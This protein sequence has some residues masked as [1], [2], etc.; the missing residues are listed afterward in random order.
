MNVLIF[1]RFANG[2]EAS[3][4][5]SDFPLVS[6]AN[7]AS[8]AEQ[9]PPKILRFMLQSAARELLPY[10]RVAKCLRAIVP[11]AQR[12]EIHKSKQ[13]KAAHY[14]NLLVCS[15]IWHC[16]IC[17]SKI[18]EERRKELSSAVAGWMGSVILVTFTMSHSNAE[19]LKSVL[20]SLL[21]AHRDL[22]SGN[23]FKEM[24]DYFGWNGSVKA[25]EITH[26]KNGWHP[27]IHELIFLTNK[28]NEDTLKRLE[29][30]ITGRWRHC[31]KKISKF[32][33]VERGVTLK[34]GDNAVGDYVS[35][36]GD[37]KIKQ[38]WTLSHE[39]TKQI[40]K[41]GKNDGQSPMQLLYDYMLGDK[42][43]GKL[44]QEYAIVCKGK[45]QLVWSRGMRDILKI[46]SEQTDEEI[47]EKLPNDTYLLASLTRGQWYDVLSHNAVGSILL[48]AET[49]TEEDFKAWLTLTLASY[50]EH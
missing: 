26:G 43:S 16:P 40:V 27:H 29:I 42:M 24:S 11:T 7:I 3:I 6:I 38:D 5:N 31:L 21:T 44:W 34:T 25:L 41:R 4:M 18:S 50:S 20:N 22:K 19:P 35:K 36:F 45:H 1:A 2:K 32:A 23:W 37:T 47:G 15:R 48:A 17:A 8:K 9:I 49:K 12:V 14:R 10:E 13:G 39:M 46:G 28:P 33:S 30:A